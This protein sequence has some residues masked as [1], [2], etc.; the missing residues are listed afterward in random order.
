MAEP[1]TLDPADQTPLKVLEGMLATHKPYKNDEC[2]P[3]GAVIKMGFFFD[4]FGRHRDHDSPSTSRYSNIC[5]LWEAHCERLDKRQ[6]G[7]ANQFCCRFYYSGLGTELNPT[8]DDMIESDVFGP[9]NAAPSRIVEN[10]LLGFLP[11]ASMTRATQ[12][13]LAS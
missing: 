6:R 8:E 13:A 10:K 12:L 2:I 4:G 3:C 9:L 5:R 7:M 11:F 1:T